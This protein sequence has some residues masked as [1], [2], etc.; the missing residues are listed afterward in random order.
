M[1]IGKKNLGLAEMV[2][3]DKSFHDK[4]LNNKE[5]LSDNQNNISDASGK[6][7]R[8]GCLVSLI[9]GILVC[10]F[11]WHVSP[12]VFIYTGLSA[13]RCPSCGHPYNASYVEA[14]DAWRSCKV[15]KRNYNLSKEVAYNSKFFGTKPS[16]AQA[17]GFYIQL[18]EEKC[19]ECSKWLDRP[20]ESCEKHNEYIKIYNAIIAPMRTGRCPDCNESIH[21]DKKKDKRTAE[22]YE[23][24]YATTLA[25][26]R[27][28]KYHEFYQWVYN[29]ID[30]Q[31]NW[32]YF[33]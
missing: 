6:T 4:N 31:T 30:E 28:C 3:E 32:G 29:K 7:R 8:H 17:A 22:I 12:F 16:N 18:Y 10:L 1:R 9:I 5:T 20:N 14:E 19:L 2:T 23:A 24:G 13:T 26:V 11:I 33:F 27:S 21:W 25:R 15:H